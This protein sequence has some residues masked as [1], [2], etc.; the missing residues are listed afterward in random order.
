MFTW[1]FPCTDLSKAGKQKGLVNTRSGLVYEVIRI[2][3]N[4]KDK[5]KV[6]I[7]ENV[8]DLVQTKFVNEFNDIQT[9]LERLGYKNYTF[10]MNAKDYEAIKSFVKKPFSKVNNELN[11]INQL[12]NAF[13][14]FH[15]FDGAQSVINDKARVTA[16]AI[17]TLMSKLK[18]RIDSLNTRYKVNVVYKTTSFAGSERLPISSRNLYVKFEP[19]PDLS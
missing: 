17:D 7:M 12:P 19:M 15:E 9:D 6:L 4:T 11:T 10:V 14:L 3:E 2:L 8:I 16:K 13:K 5:P 18:L 1:S